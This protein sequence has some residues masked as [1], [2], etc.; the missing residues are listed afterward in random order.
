MSDATCDKVGGNTSSPTNCRGN[1]GKYWVFTINNPEDRFR[2]ELFLDYIKNVENGR[3]TSCMYQTEKGE[4]GTEHLQGFLVASPKVRLSW[5]KKNVHPYAHFEIMRGKI[6]DSI[7]YCSK[8]ET[9]IDGPYEYGVDQ[10]RIGQGKRNDII[11][12]QQMIRESREITQ[13]II[14]KP[15]FAKYGNYFKDYKHFLDTQEHQERMSNIFDNVVLRDYQKIF[16]DRLMQQD[17]RQ[18]L[19]IVDVL[20]GSGKTFFAKYM[21]SRYNAFIMLNGASKDLMEAYDNQDIAILNIVRSEE[22][23]INYSVIE[24][25]K[26][27]IIF[28]KKYHSTITSRESI[29]LLV[30]SNFMPDTYKLSSDRWDLLKI[31]TNGFMDI[32]N[33][34]RGRDINKPKITISDRLKK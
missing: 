20:G 13:D 18:I 27:G 9:K 1:E 31:D 14:E 16:F 33:V 32:V 19:W 10:Y 4:K 15:A 3:I 25:L 29:K 28:K 26:D 8:S 7:A 11:E 5:L 34:D 2:G 23:I 22:E 6:S 30:F 24:N 12:I 21:K 17:H